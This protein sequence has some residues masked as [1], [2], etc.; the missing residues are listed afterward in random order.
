MH[1]TITKF[2]RH[3]K[4]FAS[5]NSPTILTAIG[6]AGT[7]STA[8]LAGKA[9]FKAAEVIR[10]QESLGGLVEAVGEPL[11]LDGREKLRLVWKLYIPA[12]ISGTVT[13]ICVVGANSISNRR[14]AAL[15]TAFS[16]S[17]TAFMEYKDKVVE[18]IGINKE[19]KIRDELAQDQVNRNP[20]TSREVIITGSGDVLCYETMS[21]RY[22][23]SNMETLR[24][25]Q[26]DVN[27]QIINDM[28][29]SVND[30][31]RKVGLPPTGYGEEVGWNTMNLLEL[32]FS[33]VLS[34][35]GKPCLAVGYSHIP[36]RDYY[37]FP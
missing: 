32:Q 14:G 16:L 20:V 36:I 8:I 19:R 9:S 18:Q 6:A 28:Y 34:E 37:R 23:N 24:R 35:D 21:G 3:A 1:T 4:K 2:L 22:F 17:E 25:A 10:E 13:V 30:F 33:S 12:A 29:A 5:D 11:F 7:L 26:N 27:A 31:C 15:A